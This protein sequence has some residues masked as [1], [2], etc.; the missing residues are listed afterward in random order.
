MLQCL[1]GACEI[2]GSEERPSDPPRNKNALAKKS[3]FSNLML[4]SGCTLPFMQVFAESGLFMILF[5]RQIRAKSGAIPPIS[6][7]VTAH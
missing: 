1:V 5:T 6:G 4:P 7:M 3:A 2:P